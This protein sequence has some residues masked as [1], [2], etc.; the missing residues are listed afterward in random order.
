MKKSCLIWL[1]AVIF[2]GV[3]LS[4]YAQT[5]GKSSSR[6]N[7]KSFGKNAP[8]LYVPA[9]TI[10]VEMSLQKPPAF[11]VEGRRIRMS[12]GSNTP[13]SFKQWLVNEISFGI[14]YNPGKSASVSALMLEGVRVELY[15]YAPG[16]ARDKASFRWL[17]GTQ[18]LHCLIVEPGQQT[19]R[20]F[21]SLFLPAAYVYQ[22]FP[23]DRGGKYAIRALEGVVVITDRN[24]NILGR[25]AFGYRTRLSVSRAR[26]L[27]DS[28]N[29]L[30]AQNNLKQQVT[31]WPRE[32]TPWMW[33]DADRFELPLTTLE[34][35]P[36]ASAGKAAPV[37]A[38]N[39]GKESEED[40]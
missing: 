2:C 29:E 11:S 34:A 13:D 3:M 20:F 33:L 15:L 31:L 24:N 30:R 21:A 26:K 17:C 12:A 22:H 18:T 7:S 36:S 23:Q 37:P 39:E 27:I 6:R 9:E 14:S 5:S 32:K 10:N 38:A 4:S 8:M 16:T 1:T 40:K 28:V 35:P 25:R 19:R